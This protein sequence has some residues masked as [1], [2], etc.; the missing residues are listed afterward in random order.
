M[1]EKLPSVWSLGVANPPRLPVIC[2]TQQPSNLQI[3]ALGNLATCLRE[4]LDKY[5]KVKT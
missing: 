5:L 3:F 2:S 4:L 1:A